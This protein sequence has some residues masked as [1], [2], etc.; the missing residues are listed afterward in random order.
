VKSALQTN[1][2]KTDPVK[3]FG[4]PI[5]CLSMPD[6]LD[7]IEQFVRSQSTHIIVTADSASIVI[8][9]NDPELMHIMQSA[10]LVTPDSVG[11]AWALKRKLGKT[12]ERVSGVDVVEKLCAQSAEKNYRIFLLGSKPGVAELAKE[13]LQAKYPGCQIVGTH[14]GYFQESDDMNVA[15]LVAASKPNI[16]FVAL[17]MPRQEK[18]IR[19]TQ[20]IIHAQVAIG[21]G[22]SLDVFSGK[23]KRAPKIVQKLKLEW[24]YRFV[25][26]P[27]K[28]YKIKLLPQ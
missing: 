23:A 14:H 17:G 2:L 16:L 6:V 10:S 22:G 18:F 15:E 7:Q 3:I 4:V 26:N 21:V 24:L 11:V 13:K 27:R 8:A 19:A 28:F 1:N 20:H 5:H 9:L 12:I 25:Q